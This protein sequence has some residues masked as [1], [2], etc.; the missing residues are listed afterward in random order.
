MI[1]SGRREEPLFF[2]LWGDIRARNNVTHASRYPSFAAGSTNSVPC[3]FWF[4]S[5]LGNE[6]LLTF[7]RR[8]GLF[9]IP[10]SFVEYVVLLRTPLYIYIRL[11]H[12][13]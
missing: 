1:P 6:R 7:H 5:P 11:A 2:M 8:A 4:G 12:V 3:G 9:H 13:A 10:A